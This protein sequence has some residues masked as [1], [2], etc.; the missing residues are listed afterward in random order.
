VAGAAADA[1]AAD[2]E[3]ELSTVSVSKSASTG[4]GFLYSAD[5]F[6]CGENAAW[7]QHGADDGAEF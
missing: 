4:A 1:Y 2:W 3:F 7:V 5:D 6:H